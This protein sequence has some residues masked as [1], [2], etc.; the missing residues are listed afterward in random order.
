MVKNLKTLLIIT[1]MSLFSC[2]SGDNY[3]S[4]PNISKYSNNN[5]VFKDEKYQ[6][7]YANIYLRLALEKS[8]NMEALDLF[9]SDMSV[10]K[11]DQLIDKLSNIAKSQ[12]RYEDLIEISNYWTK[13]NS[14]SYKA[15]SYG[16]SA[17]VELNKKNVARNF[18]SNFVNL[19][20]PQS[21][22]DFARILFELQSNKNRKNVV[23]F[24]DGLVED[25][26]SR[27]LKM[28]YIDLL[29][30]F[31]LPHDVIEN[32]RKINIFNDRH[33]TRLYANSNL[34]IG[35]LHLAKEILE[36]FLK[37]KKLT[38]R[39]V[40]LELAEVYLHLND[41]LSAKKIIDNLLVSTPDDPDLIYDIS[42]LLFES[43]FYN[44]S[45]K[46]LAKIVVNESRVDYLR[47]MLDL[48]KNNLTEAILHFDRVDNYSY[49]F[50]A[51]FAK[52]EAILKK[53]GYIEAISFLDSIKD[54]SSEQDMMRVL[55]KK[56]EILR[57][58]KKYEQII[59]LTK[60]HI[61]NHNN[62][63]N[64]IYSR[65]MAYEAM[66][67]IDKMEIDLREILKVDFE[68]T[69]TLNALGY[70]LT[71][72]TDRYKEALGMIERAHSHDPGNSA[73]ID[74]LAW[75]Y[76]KLGNMEKALKFSKLAYEKDKDPEIIEHYCEILLRM[77][78]YTEYENVI[79]EN[80]KTPENEKLIE[81]L[82]RL[83]SETSI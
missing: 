76:F 60:E 4:N 25:D 7:I 32:V 42:I 51:L 12:Y 17:A 15:L 44:E 36:K 61:R 73:I 38:G 47:G 11:N 52:S 23:S 21:N 69:N 28:A 14:S 41:I 68:N 59:N 63:I 58:N 31:N 39:Q 3:D 81:K 46:Y 64:I 80:D 67:E 56:I 50:P 57:V 82:K 27:E 45:E 83:K 65:A 5:D 6:E 34:T 66:G 8:L 40:L 18:Y 74:S 77:G 1:S 26:N 30:T 75:V 49:K 33:L 62:D 78:L 72:H 79:N 20:N 13:L 29:Y 16:F 24:I 35:N 71:I 43:K 22:R 37:D 70:S 10:I 48:E 9:L 2:S 53:N 19:T 55:M 54:F